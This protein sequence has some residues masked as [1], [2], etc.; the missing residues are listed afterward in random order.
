MA[1]IKQFA[2]NVK[3]FDFMQ[4]VGETIFEKREDIYDL[5]RAELA[6]GYR[7]TGE[8]IGVYANPAYERMKR[9]MNPSA[10]GW[11]D[12]KLTGAFQG[13]ITL[14]MIGKATAMVYSQD[15]KFK[16]IIGQY[17][18][19]LLGIPNKRLDELVE[20]RGF[21]SLLQEKTRNGI[22]L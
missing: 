3:N 17:G 22:G 14:R 5:N 8:R 10:G 15:E 11:V 19:D 1:T 4:A 21:K 13:E 20:Q 18:N 6:L 9:Q 12:L 7:V 16:K 2:T